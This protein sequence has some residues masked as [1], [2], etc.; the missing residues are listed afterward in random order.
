[1]LRN[2]L[3]TELAKTPGTEMARLFNEAQVP[4]RP[5]PVPG[6]HKAAPASPRIYLVE[7]I[8]GSKRSEQ[9]FASGEGKQ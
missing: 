1:V 3:D 6:T 8:N 5:Q 9:K 4:V 2:P 7:V